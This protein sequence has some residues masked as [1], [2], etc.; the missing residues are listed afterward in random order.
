MQ[1][2]AGVAVVEEVEAAVDPEAVFLYRDIMLRVYRPG[3]GG[4]N[5]AADFWVSVATE[6]CE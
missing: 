3:A 2:Y 6:H 1:H 4:G 5:D